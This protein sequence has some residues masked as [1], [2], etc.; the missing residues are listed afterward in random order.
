METI[1][2]EDLLERARA[3]APVVAERAGECMDL[4]RLPPQTEK[5]FHEAGFYRCLQPKR[6]G[7][8]ELDFGTHTELA[9]EV[10][11]GCASSAWNLCIIACHGW[12]LGM[13]PTEA[14]DEIWGDNPTATV[15]SSFLT[16][17]PPKVEPEGE[18]FRMNARFGFSS[19]S[20]YCQAAIVQVPVDFGHGS[21][22]AFVVMPR[23]DYEVVDTWFANGLAGTGSND[24]IVE[25]A[26]IPSHRVLPVRETK[27]GP[28]PGSTANDSHI[29]RIPMYAAFP[30]NLVGPA[31]GAVRG[32]LDSVADGLAERVTM[33]GVNLAQV[34]S[35]QTRIAEVAARVE[36]AWSTLVPI[37]EEIN[38]DARNGVIPDIHR[39]THYRLMVAY[40]GRLCVEAM[41]QLFPL[42]GGRGLARGNPVERAWRDVHAIAQHIGINWDVH[43]GTYGAVRLGGDCPDPKL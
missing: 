9:M 28:T 2:R 5:D 3:M 4:R 7:G 31:I 6:Y 39:R 8:L 10:G 19:G 18:G 36:S 43:S 42:I 1:T 20:D 16:L 34:Q 13:F 33:T 23:D 26:Y 30:F 17:G 25:D 12:M 15:S 11:A 14:Q 32:A 29:Y 38:S 41:E 21:E 35:A 37:R 40:V 24:L 27:G 22:P